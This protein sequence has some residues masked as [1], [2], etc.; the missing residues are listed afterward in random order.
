MDVSTDT[1]FEAV[2]HRVQQPRFKAK[3]PLL[4]RRRDAY[5]KGRQAD[6]CNDLLGAILA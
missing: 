5:S 3:A 6:N 2:Q 4:P 1:L